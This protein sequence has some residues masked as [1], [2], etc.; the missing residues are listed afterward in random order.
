[1]LTSG[2][3]PPLLTCTHVHLSGSPNEHLVTV[4]DPK[5]P[6]Q[7]QTKSRALQEVLH[8]NK[9]DF[10]PACLPT[11]EAKCLAQASL[12]KNLQNNYGGAGS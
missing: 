12:I 11:A 5:H 4:I 7:Q 9:N 1:M 2:K 6:Q 8:R 10:S 3:V